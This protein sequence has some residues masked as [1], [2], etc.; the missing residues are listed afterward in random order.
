MAIVDRRRCFRV[1]DVMFNVD[2][3]EITPITL[4]MCVLDIWVYV[5]VYPVRMWVGACMYVSVKAIALHQ[6]CV[7]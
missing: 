4:V 5:I 3:G 6:L 7:S 1:D 2:V